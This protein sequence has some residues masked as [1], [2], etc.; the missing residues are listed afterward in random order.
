MVVN[1]MNLYVVFNNHIDFFQVGILC[2]H[3]L[4]ILNIHYIKEISKK[5]IIKRCT[6]RVIE[7]ENVDISLV[8]SYDELSSTSSL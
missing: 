4:C 5:Y 2:C 7:G 3:C 8:S 6:K 1:L